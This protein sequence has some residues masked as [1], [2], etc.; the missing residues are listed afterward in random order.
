MADSVA[1]YEAL[2][3]SDR[4]LL[5]RALTSQRDVG[6]VVTDADLRIRRV[7]KAPDTFRGLVLKVGGSLPALVPPEDAPGL[8]QELLRVLATGQPLLDRTQPMPERPNRPPSGLVVSLAALR[9][10]PDALLVTLADR[11]D[12][13][14]A[15]RSRDLLFRATE[16]VGESL[17]VVVTAQQI[18]D[19]L[20]PALG[21]AAGV[22]L[23]DEVFLG[24]EPPRRGGAE[25][26]LHR[27]AVTDSPGCPCPPPYAQPG[28]AMPPMPPVPI[29][30]MYRRGDVVPIPDPE[31]MARELDHDPALMARLVPSAGADYLGIALFAR[32]VPLGSMEVWRRHG[33]RPFDAHDR[34]VFGEI[35]AR[36]ALAIDNARRH[37]REIE[38]VYRL[39]RSMLPGHARTTAAETVARYLPSDRASGDWYDVIPLSGCRVA[40]VVGD[41]VGH[42]VDAAA[43]M[44]R[45]RTAARTLATLDQAPDEVL[46]HLDDIVVELAEDQPPDAPDE[47]LSRLVGIAAEATGEPP[48][49]TDGPTATTCCVAVYDPVGHRLA[50]AT[51]GHP[52]PLLVQPDGSA[53]FVHLDPGPPLGVGWLPFEVTEIALP[54]DATLVFFTDGLVESRTRDIGAGMD[55]LR[56]QAT[57]LRPGDDLGDLANRLTTFATARDREDDA[58]LLIARLREIPAEDTT[59]WEFPAEE[60]QVSSA[61]THA[62]RWLAELAASD[63]LVATAKLI[64]S[65]LATNAVRYGSGPRMGL[66]LIRDAEEL[67]IEVSDDASTSPRLRHARP[68]DEGGRGLLIVAQLTGGHWG[69]RHTEQGKTIWTRISWQH[70]PEPVPTIPLDLDG[71]DP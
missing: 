35:A 39:H 48:Q 16:S 41:A 6:V 54:P 58:T 28:E 38:L 30:E 59:A 43:M 4:D 44:G 5:W 33:A 8:E 50:I 20:V 19:L 37:T 61:R 55:T 45:L 68:R 11:T 56:A 7:W 15:R 14:W 63:D 70:P 27:A 9:A 51:A 62:T 66:R 3:M 23:A 71:L 46:T 67:V 25:L 69:A 42:G 1:G 32:G 22:T 34:Q 60:A 53:A 49:A 10:G 24:R 40:F 21:D 17:D 47:V 26:G 29:V 52:P 13:H 2:P 36:T 64:V 18:T 65:E 31:S 57:G 12:E